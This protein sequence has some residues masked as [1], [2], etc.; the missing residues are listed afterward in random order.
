MKRRELYT[1]ILDHNDGTYVL[2]VSGNSPN[3]AMTNWANEVS[4]ENL[5]SW[6]LTRAEL[7]DLSNDDPAPLD[8]CVNV[9]CVTSSVSAGLALVNIVATRS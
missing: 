7:R 4:D 6:G 1:V 8:G 5:A 2:Q 3:E 9:W